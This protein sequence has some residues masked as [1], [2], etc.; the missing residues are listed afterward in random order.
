MEG[1][2]Y[3]FMFR[4]TQ[5]GNN[6]NRSSGISGFWGMCSLSISHFSFSVIG[7][8]KEEIIRQKHMFDS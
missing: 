8:K 4:K 3:H 2:E 1:L 7:G 6:L 5:N